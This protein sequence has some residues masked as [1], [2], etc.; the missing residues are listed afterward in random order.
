M[1]LSALQL[2]KIINLNDYESLEKLILSGNK[3]INFNCD[4]NEKGQYKTLVSK[5]IEVRARECFDLLLEIPDLEILSLNS[6]LSGLSKAIEFYTGAPNP[7]NEYY[8]RKL[9]EKNIKIDISDI[10]ECIGFSNFFQIMFG[11]INKNFDNIRILYLKCI[12]KNN[13]ETIYY[14]SNYI[15][16]NFDNNKIK[17]FYNIVCKF[18]V[19]TD[20]IGVFEYLKEKLANYFVIENIPIIYLCNKPKSKI[21]NY[22]YDQMERMSEQE[23]NQISN[24]KHLHYLY[25]NL[26][27]RENLVR[28]LKLKINFEDISET[29]TKIILN[30][31]NSLQKTYYYN[32]DNFINNVLF[33]YIALIKNG[34]IKS[35]PLDSLNSIIDMLP[36]NIKT[37]NYYSCR[38]YSGYTG[39]VS[40]MKKTKMIFNNYGWDFPQEIATI[41]NEAITLVYGTNIINKDE[42]DKL[43]QSLELEYDQL[44]A[45][46]QKKPTKRTIKKNK[47]INV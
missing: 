42:Q 12:E 6:D 7:G 20:N 22:L 10:I 34:L 33:L 21:F 38:S 46:K 40:L 1:S 41:I 27:I 8:L 28:I 2:M 45:V 26:E 13:M 11:K 31:I 3:K 24:I 25:G 23:L 19:E 44:T 36:K 17:E 18:T 43:I 32:V 15:E 47:D 29:I 35:N 16:Q 39:Y 14:L 5:A 30:T 4:K 9:L 37:N